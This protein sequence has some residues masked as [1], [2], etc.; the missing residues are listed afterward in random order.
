YF[1][2]QLPFDQNYSQYCLRSKDYECL[3][4]GAGNLLINWQKWWH[5]IFINFSGISI[6]LLLVVGTYLIINNLSQE[7]S[8][9]TLNFIRMSPRSEVNILMGKLLGV[10]IL[11]YL[12]VILAIPLYL[13]VGF[14][15]HI[16][17][18]K[19]L[20]FWA[21]LV[22]S[23]VLFYS[24]ALLCSLVGAGSS[25]SF[26]ALSGGIAVLFLLFLMLAMGNGYTVEKDPS[27]WLKLFS[28]F[29]AISYLFPTSESNAENWSN[30]QWYYLPLSGGVISFVGFSLF[31][32]GLWS[33]WIWQAVRRCFR[34]PNATI[35][36]KGQSYAIVASFEVMILGFAVPDYQY[37]DAMY[38]FGNNLSLLSCFNLILLLGLIATLL[39]QRQN[40]QDWARYKQVKNPKSQLKLQLFKDSADLVWG[41]KSPGV[42]AIGINLA[43]A[44]TPILFWILLQPVDSLVKTKVIFG[45]LFFI[46]WMMISATIAQLTLMMKSKKRPLWAAGIVATVIFLPPTILGILGISPEENPILWL[47]SSFFY[48]GIENATNSAIFIALLGEWTVLALLNLQL[49]RQLQ[50][51]GESATKKLLATHSY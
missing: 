32:Y 6:F 37:S 49:V 28:P 25:S 41:E 39:P 16:P 11:L 13:W 14:S 47:F 45:V 43:I 31:N 46:S 34:N 24:A 42:V 17:L 7:E 15:A 21:I 29:T 4:D 23:S 40:L 38:I 48:L 3:K 12:V 35:L 27:N 30:F 1:Y 10:P 9:G 19:I 50:K 36:N 18:G 22:G 20:S 26:L 5:A 33:Y 44:A 8:R 51:A 2:S